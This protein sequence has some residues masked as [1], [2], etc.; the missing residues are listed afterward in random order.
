MFPRRAFTLIE[1]LVVISIIALLIAI[2]LPA[3]SS[4]RNAAKGSQCAGNVKSS[5]QAGFVFSVDNKGLVPRDWQSNWDPFN[6]ARKLF[7]EVCS[8]SLGGPDP[9]RSEAERRRIQAL[10]GSARSQ[11]DQYLAYHF[12]DMPA[13]HCPDWKGR[14]EPASWDTNVALDEDGSSKTMSRA[15]CIT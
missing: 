2:L 8:G 9:M 7:A 14:N 3:L 15:H 10:R 5:S 11:Q 13:L 1:L 4:A 12:D 6:R